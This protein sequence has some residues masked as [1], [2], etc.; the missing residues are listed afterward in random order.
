MEFALS[1]R[2]ISPLRAGE[3]LGV[4]PRTIAIYLGTQLKV[5]FRVEMHGGR[6]K[7]SAIAFED[8]EAFRLWLIDRWSKR[9]SRTADVKRLKRIG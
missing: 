9:P 4:G 3:I 6:K 1:D 7:T 8:L 5:A 2:F